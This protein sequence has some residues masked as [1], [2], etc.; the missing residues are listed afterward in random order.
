MAI[1]L[2][3]ESSTTPNIQNHDDSRMTRYAY[4]G[5]DGI[6]QGIGSEVSL[7]SSGLQAHFGSGRIVLQG[8]EIDIDE[9]GV[10]LRL[11]NNSF[12]LIYLQVNLLTQKAEIRPSFGTDAFPKLDP[13]D[14]LTTYPTG[15]ASMILYRIQTRDMAI[16]Y[17][18]KAAPIILY[19]KELLELVGT[20]IAD[21]YDEL[22]RL[23]DKLSKR[24][25]YLHRVCIRKRQQYSGTEFNIEYLRVCFNFYS[26][27]PAALKLTELYV[28]QALGGTSIVSSYP[29]SG[30]WY[31]SINSEVD[32]YPITSFRADSNGL[33]V[34]TRPSGTS[35][36]DTG[37]KS[38]PIDDSV[39]MIDSVIPIGSMYDY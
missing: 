38:V 6:V 19:T 34:N 32:Y 25:L 31:G 12:I 35:S 18:Q 10:D 22:E 15:T 27:N 20:D 26:F 17:T 7:S 21:T 37:E 9:A 36:S 30:W 5:Y 4:G 14:D 24:K 23:E 1:K 16:V 8:W 33:T 2:L 11:Y 13:G 39:S 3:R 28:E 29:C